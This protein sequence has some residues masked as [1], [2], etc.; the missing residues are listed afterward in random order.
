MIEVEVIRKPPWYQHEKNTWID[1]NG[2]KSVNIPIRWWIVFRDADDVEDLIL[3]LVCRLPATN[4]SILEF[5]ER[6]EMEFPTAWRVACSCLCSRPRCFNRLTTGIRALHRFES[7]FFLQFTREL[8]LDWLCCC[9]RDGDS[10]C[11][12]GVLEEALSYSGIDR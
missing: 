2:Y 4:F 12:N 7:W 1:K 8:F 11:Q 3:C 10:F 9:V 6:S 5:F